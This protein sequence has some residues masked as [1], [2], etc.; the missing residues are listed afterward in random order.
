MD[1]KRMAVHDGDGIRTTFFLKGCPLQCKWCHNP[2][3]LS[4]LPQL[5]FLQKKCQ[6]CGSCHSVC[7]AHA[8]KNGIHQFD[9]EKCKGC[10]ACVS[11]CPHGALIF[12]GM[13]MSAED[14][15]K[16]ALEDRVFY[17]ISG[18]GVTLSGGEPLAQYPF[19]SEMLRILKE[20][21]ISTAVDTSGFAPRYAVDAVLS[22]T[23]VFLY[24]IKCIDK[25][26]HVEYTG[27]SNEIILD[28]LLYLNNQGKNIEI[29]VP[30]IPGINDHQMNKI[31][32]FL[33]PLQNIRKVKVLPYH[34]MAKSKYESLGKPYLL[35]DIKTPSESEI[36]R[37]VAL[38][39]K[40][41]L[42]VVNGKD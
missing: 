42:N 22:Y 17:E 32:Q 20:N 10:G 28:N 39:S 15:V 13:E 23:D 41:G 21:N 2:E 12:H 36:D 31:G 30:L 19:A 33:K 18:G 37:A 11:S 9:K 38:L 16:I 5:R 29:R 3:S 14:A 8:M 24:D 7:I 6:N 40:Y 27:Q 25:D 4:F 34:N 35:L 26:L 1:I